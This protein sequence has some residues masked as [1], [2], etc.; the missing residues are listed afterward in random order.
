MQ[1]AHIKVVH[2]KRIRSIFFIKQRH[3]NNTAQKNTVEYKFEN[4]F[5]KW[6]YKNNR[7][8]EMKTTV[9]LKLW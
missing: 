5:K 2:N 9:I 3:V 7:Q 4:S 8:V 6:Y 1:E